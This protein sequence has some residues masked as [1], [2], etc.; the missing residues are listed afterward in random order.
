M[1]GNITLTF[2]KNPDL[3]LLLPSEFHIYAT[4]DKYEIGRV[5]LN[6]FICYDMKT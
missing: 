3:I 5:L 2:T 4:K 6:I 1:L